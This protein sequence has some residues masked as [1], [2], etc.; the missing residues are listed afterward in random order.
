M[1]PHPKRRPRWRL[2]TGLAALSLLLLQ[3]YPV[4][5]ADHAVA[6][7]DNP[8]SRAEA[9]FRLKRLENLLLTQPSATAVLE[10][11]CKT[12][13]IARDPRVIAERPPAPDKPAPPDVRTH[14]RIASG[15]TIHYRHVRLLCGG[16]LL[17]EADNWYVADRLTTEM[18]RLLQSTDTPF[19]RV[20]SAL[21]FR[22]TTLSSQVFWSSRSAAPD[23][24]GDLAFPAH[25]ITNEAVLHAVSGLPIAEVVESYTAGVLGSPPTR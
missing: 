24:R 20:I 4:K 23:I 19:G 10:S 17:S 6:W 5:A 22:R 7:P 1:D 16:Q 21:H 11:W 15:E 18:N 2:P 12:Y 3:A 9:E 25:V 14:L 8:A 13:Q